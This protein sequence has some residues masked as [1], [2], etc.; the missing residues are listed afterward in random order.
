MIFPFWAPFSTGQLLPT[1]LSLRHFAHLASPFAYSLGKPC[2][3]RHPVPLAPSC[4][5]PPLAL[6]VQARRL[7]S[8]GF[9]G[10]ATIRGGRGVRRWWSGR[11]VNWDWR[12]NSGAPAQSFPRR[13]QLI[14]RNRL[15]RRV[16]AGEVVVPSR[17]LACVR[18][19]TRAVGVSHAFL[20]SRLGLLCLGAVWGFWHSDGPG[21][22]H[23][24]QPPPA[25]TGMLRGQRRAP[26]SLP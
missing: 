24:A 21:D 19:T 8:V 14:G 20:F 5:H 3:P 13:A 7:R 2:L 15:L 4:R 23:D 18:G 22:C 12:G 25:L 9:L 17:K 10:R 16:R 6:P 1:R 26:V 11:E